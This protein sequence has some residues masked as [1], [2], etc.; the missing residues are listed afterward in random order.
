MPET[1]WGLGA[2]L[3]FLA[4]CLSSQFDFR[5]KRYAV[6]QETPNITGSSTAREHLD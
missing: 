6:R 5:G 4:S 1:G 2:K 3:L